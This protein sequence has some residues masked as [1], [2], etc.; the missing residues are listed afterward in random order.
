MLNDGFT[1][2]KLMKSLTNFQNWKIPVSVRMNQKFYNQIPK[3]GIIQFVHT[4][5]WNGLP[6][7]IDNR[8]RGFKIKY[9][10]IG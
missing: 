6:I 1:Y 10:T 3:I 8:I 2:E 7:K 4:S 9:I 5:I